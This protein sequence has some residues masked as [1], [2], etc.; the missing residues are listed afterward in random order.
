MILKE[1]ITL[2]FSAETIFSALNYKFIRLIQQTKKKNYKIHGKITR[3][4]YF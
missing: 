3:I 1:K 2:V 4:K